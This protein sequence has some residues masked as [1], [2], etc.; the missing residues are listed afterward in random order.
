[1]KKFIDFIIAH[2]ERNVE[3][4]PHRKQR[5][6]EFPAEILGD[7]VQMECGGTNILAKML[8]DGR[9]PCRKLRQV[10]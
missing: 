1:M 10:V 6:G 2:S 8:K 4:I 5:G 3:H 9:I 7:W